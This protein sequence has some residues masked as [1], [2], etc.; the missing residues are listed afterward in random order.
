MRS[1]PR[2]IRRAQEILDAQDVQVVYQY[3]LALGRSR[4]PF[5]SIFEGSS[6]GGSSLAKQFFGNNS[7]FGGRSPFG[8]SLTITDARPIVVEPSVADIEIASIPTN[9]RPADYRGAVGQYAIATQASPTQVK[10]GD[11]ITL[12]IGIQG[13]GPMELVQ[14]PPLH[15]LAALTE[16]FKVAD[17]SLAGVVKDDVKVFATTIR[18]RHEGVVEIP[19][20]PFSYF[21]P[22]LEQFITVTSDPISIEVGKAE[23][24]A[25]DAIV[26]N[27]KSASGDGKMQ[28]AE[29]APTFQLA[30]SRGNS[31]LSST[32]A[33]TPA[34]LWWLAII[35]PGIWMS[36]LFLNRRN[37]SSSASRG[38]Q[39]REI[40]NAQTATALAESVQQALHQ[41]N[42]NSINSLQRD[43]PVDYPSEQQ[44]RIREFYSGCDQSVYGGSRETLASLKAQAKQIVVDIPAKKTERW[45][46]P[47]FKRPVYKLASAGLAAA[48]IAVVGFTFVKSNDLSNGVSFATSPVTA[49]VSLDRQQQQQL[50]KEANVAYERGSTLAKSDA[51]ESKLAFASA[52][53]KYQLLI[54]S[55]VHNSNLFSNLG[56]S[57]LQQDKIGNA[58]AS[59][60][61]ARR[62]DPTNS[63]AVHNLKLAKQ[64][65]ASDANADS[66]SSGFWTNVA[67]R[68]LS[69]VPPWSA[70][71]LLGVSWLGF[72]SIAAFR[73]SRWSVVQNWGG[74][75]AGTS[76]AL[77]LIA[78]GWIVAQDQAFETLRTPIAVVTDVAV[79]VR[80]GAGE[81]FK[82]ASGFVL[83][84]GAQWRVLQQR[85][86]WCQVES[87]SGSTGWVKNSDVVV[88]PRV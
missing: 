10:A 24:L 81:E 35:P 52:A 84:E 82:P 22:E 7:P 36:V 59:F 68:A 72:W 53:G 20:I 47:K 16:D 43:I 73:L 87:D 33:M 28:T 26:G 17:D 31:V 9:G 15:A 6:F 61:T 29:A 77:V 37:G 65:I 56:N 32:S 27:G 62:I 60:E 58:I 5:D 54:E 1:M 76:A 74:T 4:D 64:R 85:G 13:T 41:G 8:R 51:A 50:L 18:P 39:L 69:I 34:K 66:A 80:S 48:L 75:L 3:P 55:G 42:P 40:R 14:A 46:V 12:Q 11:P 21:D 63:D 23:T 45:Q 71:A 86:D 78:C 38:Q 25:L 49:S 30:N 79:D 88:V 70:W 83:S 2:S 44:H 19:A 57:F 67:D